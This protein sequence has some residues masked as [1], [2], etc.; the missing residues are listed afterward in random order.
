MCRGAGACSLE[1]HQWTRGGGAGRGGGRGPSTGHGGSS[2]Q[3]QADSGPGACL[4]LPSQPEKAGYPSAGLC[5]SLNARCMQTA[6]PPLLPQ[7]T[8]SSYGRHHHQQQRQHSQASN[9]WSWEQQWRQQ[10]AAGPA[11]QCRHAAALCGACGSLRCPTIT[12][13]RIA[14]QKLL[15]TAITERDPFPRAAPY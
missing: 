4:E 8:L 10:G 1:L 5:T 15:V 11:V 14:W 6:C 13:H 3:L 2:S 9:P 7:E 12:F